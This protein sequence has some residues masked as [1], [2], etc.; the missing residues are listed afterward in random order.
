[1]DPTSSISRRIAPPKTLPELFA[2]MGIMILTMVVD[3]SLML[4]EASAI[5]INDNPCYSFAN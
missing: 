4:F 2:S 1:M 3:D 5:T